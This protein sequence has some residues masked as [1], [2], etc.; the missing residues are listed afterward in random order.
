MESSPNAVLTAAEQVGLLSG[1]V[2]AKSR[3][4]Q[5][6]SGGRHEEEARAAAAAVAS[7]GSSCHSQVTAQWQHICP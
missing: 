6:A 3:A 7:A 4:K 2:S 1:D 5:F